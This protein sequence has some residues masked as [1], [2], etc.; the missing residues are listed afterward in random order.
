MPQVLASPVPVKNSRSLRHP[1]ISLTLDFYYFVWLLAFAHEKVVDPWR[2]LVDAK[3]LLVVVANDVLVAVE[4]L[5]VQTLI[6]RLI[7]Y[8]ANSLI[9]RAAYSKALID[10]WS[11][12]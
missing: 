11:G 1:I 5:L 2:L 4:V 7:N 9:R 3:A 6:A 12:A 10:R 8:L